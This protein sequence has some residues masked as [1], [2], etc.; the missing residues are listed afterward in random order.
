MRKWGLIIVV[1]ISSCTYHKA[2]V[3]DLPEEAGAFVSEHFASFTIHDIYFDNRHD[4]KIEVEFKDDTHIIFDEDGA[5]EVIVGGT[6]TLPLTFLHPAIPVYLKEHYP[7]DEVVRIE[8][9]KK[10]IGL[11]LKGGYEIRFNKDGSVDKIK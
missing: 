2:D 6:N 10:G 8:S 5:W 1:L 3:N 11:K 7:K 9:K 4:D